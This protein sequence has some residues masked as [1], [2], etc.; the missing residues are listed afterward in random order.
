MST[1]GDIIQII[2]ELALFLVVL[3]KVQ[4]L[5]GFSCQQP[6]TEIYWLEKPGVMIALVLIF[7][8]ETAFGKN[9]H[10]ELCQMLY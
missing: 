9:G 8:N 6:C 10:V 7:H 1:G 5:H 3:Q 2:E 4:G